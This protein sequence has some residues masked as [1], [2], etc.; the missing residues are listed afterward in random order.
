MKPGRRLNFI[1]I[2]IGAA[3]GI[4]LSLI[5]P[6]TFM[7]KSNLFGKALIGGSIF[8][9]ILCFLYDANKHSIKSINFDRHLVDF[10]IPYNSIFIIG[11]VYLAAG[12][13]G[14]TILLMQSKQLGIAN[15]IIG[16]G[17]SL[18]SGALLYIYISNR[19]LRSK[20]KG[21]P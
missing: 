6:T 2:A 18:I 10:T 11:I 5:E 1:V 9:T 19:V 21:R 4:P 3:C 15:F 20:I 12:I 14:L 7:A 17:L 8:S 13:V 16:L